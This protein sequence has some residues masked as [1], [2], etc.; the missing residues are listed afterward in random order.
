MGKRP[1]LCIVLSLA[2]VLGFTEHIPVYAKKL[3]NVATNGDAKAES[4]QTPSP[5][6]NE[7]KTNES[8]DKQDIVKLL[9][10]EKFTV[11][12][13][14][15]SMETH[16]KGKGVLIKGS[17]E[18]IVKS[19]FSFKDEIDF[20]T[21]EATHIVADGLAS[22]K[23]K[24]ELHFYLDND[25]KPFISLKLN[26]QKRKDFWNYSKNVCS[27]VKD[28]KITGKHKISFKV[29]T[30][31]K[32]NISLLMRSIFFMR[33]NVPIVSFD[34]DE[35]EGSISEMNGDASHNSECYGK[36][37]V[38]V[39][40]GYKS[41]YS[42]KKAESGTYDLEYIRGR[43]NSTWYSNK[44]P[45]KF[46]LAKSTD[47]FGMGK[48]KHWILLANYYDASMLRNKLTYWLGDEMGMKYTPQCVFVDLILNNQ[49]LGS[50]Y[51]CEQ[52]RV[53]SSRVN[54]D[55]LEADEISKNITSGSAITGGYLLGMSPYTENDEQGKIFSTEK[56][57][58][59]VIESPSFDDYFNEA[60]YN[61]IAG[62]MQ[63]TENAIYGENFKDADGK[64]YSEYMDVDAAIDYYWVQEIS[65]NGD[66]YGSSS[67]YLYKERNGK[68]F[69]G[70][71]WDFDYVA[72]GD[73]ST[74]T[75]DFSKTSAMWFEKL[76]LD[77]EFVGKLIARWQTFKE[78]LLYACQDG[79]KIDQYAAELNESQKTNYNVNEIY[80]GIWG[81]AW[82]NID[83]DKKQIIDLDNAVNNGDIDIP[84]SVTFESEVKRFKQWV[85]D[86]VAWI[87][88][89]IN[90]LKP[91]VYNITYMSDGKV[92]KKDTYVK[93]DR[94]G[95]TLP[96]AP[97]KKGYKF[98]GW[99]IKKQ[100]EKKDEKYLPDSTKI[101][102]DTVLYAK[103][104]DKKKLVQADAISFA[105][106]EFYYYIN[107]FI[108][109][110]PVYAMPFD[111]E[112]PDVTYKSSDK[113][114]VKISKDEAG[115]T[116]FSTTLI[117]GDA[118]I[119]ATAK[120]GLKASCIIHVIDYSDGLDVYKQ[121]FAL[122]KEKVTLKRGDYFRIVPKEAFAKT[123]YVDYSYTSSDESIVEVNAAGYICAK[124]AGTAYIAV[125]SSRTEKIKFCKV[126]VKNKKDKSKKK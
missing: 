97:V 43:G 23:S 22:K 29:V 115:Q 14:K 66:A 26:C 61:Y 1:V 88:K 47:F 112:L 81:E 93:N 57:H 96:E 12:D 54:I 55:D 18:D 124:K 5:D 63:K 38:I 99:Y 80:G 125:V 107:D 65:S 34:I 121:E 42:D 84:T 24:T 69:F 101:I 32:G 15:V 46:K 41:E 114:I 117:K 79:G 17:S 94:N 8:T 105:K 113:R 33:S 90:L 37:S 3:G 70:P 13:S 83:M 120:N 85:A 95:L 72:W 31:E 102:K 86:R 89:N 50:Y 119:T 118:K 77:K 44:K 126:T 16:E 73:T 68:L 104:I 92:Y 27:S 103:W 2:I 98:Q 76:M 106:K 25:E 10:E 56:E 39:P 122:N 21:T 58:R 28:A 51:L 109:S 52:I 48:N 78:K 87:D 67:T 64:H 60:Q 36:M 40:D 35:S 7:K 111:A 110:M 116:T 71:L 11:S 4:T 59:F 20:G 108:S 62:Y 53:G 123:P 6:S 82:G 30:E 49:Y 91:V 19:V 100:G 75:T 9:S 45:Y 74:S